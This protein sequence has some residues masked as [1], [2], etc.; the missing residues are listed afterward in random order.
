M[1]AQERRRRLAQFA[2]GNVHVL[3]NQKL[4]T[5]GYDFP[6]VTDVIIQGRVGSAIQFEQ[7]VG[8]VA[9]GP[10]TGGT[11]FG[12]VWQFED[13]LK[14]HGLPQSYHRY[15]TAGWRVDRLS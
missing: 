14:I 8:R 7:I 9:R 6:G 11:K 10:R 12:N 4:L 5:A 2:G 13:H 3:C 15:D 1:E